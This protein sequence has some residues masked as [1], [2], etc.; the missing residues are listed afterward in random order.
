MDCVAFGSQC[1]STTA[2][3]SEK[4]KI[5]GAKLADEGVAQFHDVLVV[6]RD[7]GRKVVRAD[8]DLAHLGLHGGEIRKRIV[9]EIDNVLIAGAVERV[10]EGGDDRGAKPGTEHVT[11]EAR[12]AIEIFRLSVAATIE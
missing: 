6:E 9:V 4:R 2:T 3:P 7:E 10:V 8:R 5:V 1:A 11:V 12:P